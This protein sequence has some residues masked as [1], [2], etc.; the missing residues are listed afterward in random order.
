[1]K[2]NITLLLTA[3]M[4]VFALTGCVRTDIGVTLNKNGTGSVSASFG[5]EKSVYDQLMALGG[6]DLFDG[7][8]P[9]A[10]KYGNTTYMTVTETKEYGSYEEI[11]EALL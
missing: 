8:T 7:K 5:I 3:L 10:V 4:L 9:E 6:S 11:K 2:K 1:M